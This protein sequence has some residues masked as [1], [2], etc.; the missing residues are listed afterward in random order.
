MNYWFFIKKYRVPKSVPGNCKTAWTLYLT[1]NCAKIVTFYITNWSSC[2][3]WS[4][5]M[6]S[7]LSDR[8]CISKS[9]SFRF[10]KVRHPRETGDSWFK[11]FFKQR[12]NIHYIKNLHYLVYFSLVIFI[13]V[14]RKIFIKSRI[15]T[16]RWFTKSRITCTNIGE[17]GPKSDL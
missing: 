3:Q 8:F 12:Q 5:T 9:Q 4:S 11:E 1:K 15:F 2:M 13:L 14:S 6:I 16:I 17:F 7:T 10:L